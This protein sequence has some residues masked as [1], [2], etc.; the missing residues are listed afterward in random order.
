[1]SDVLVVIPVYNEQDTLPVVLA[2]LRRVWPGG[3]LVVDDGSTDATPEIARAAGVFILQHKRNL[4]YGAALRAG[5]AWAAGRGYEWSITMD[6]DGQHEPAFIPDFLARIRSGSADIVSGSRYLDPALSRGP[7]PQDRVWVNRAVTALLRE[8]TG[9]PITDAFC[10][11]KAYRL[12]K[13]VRLPLSEDGYAFPVELWI[14]AA[15]A[16][17]KV[18]EIPVPL[19][20]HD[21]EKGVG[22]CPAKDRLATYLE[23][24]ARA[25]RWTCSW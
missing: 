25:L 24:A 13:V 11:F 1:M 18:E 9:Y 12:E 8:I 6:A 3:I 22:R 5:L 7:R 16:G 14:K 23:A 20:Y 4:G 10:G 19:I 2:G 17:L 21:F 15:H